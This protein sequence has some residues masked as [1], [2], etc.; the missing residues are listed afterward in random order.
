GTSATV[1]SRYSCTRAVSV[2]HPGQATAPPWV[3]ARTQ[4]T[5]P[6]SSTSSMTS[7]DNPE[8]TVPTSS[9]TSIMTDR[10]ASAHP[11]TTESAT[12]PIFRCN[13][14]LVGYFLPAESRPSKVMSK[15]LRAAFHR[16]V[17]RL[18]PFPVGSR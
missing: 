10:D 3:L 8:N 16:L 11:A 5:S 15:A 13:L 14:I 18:R 9:V 17:H 1:R 12:E 4:I 2:P 7:A 6:A